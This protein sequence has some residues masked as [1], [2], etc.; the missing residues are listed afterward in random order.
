M[1][2][3]SPEQNQQLFS[4]AT[5]AKRVEVTRGSPLKDHSCPRCRVIRK[6]I[7]LRECDGCL[8]QWCYDCLYTWNGIRFRDIWSKRK[9]LCPECI[10]ECSCAKPRCRDV[11][12]PLQHQPDPIEFLF[13]DPNTESRN[14]GAISDPCERRAFYS[15]TWGPPNTKKSALGPTNSVVGSRA[16]TTNSVVG[17]RAG[18]TRAKGASR[19]RNPKR[20][21]NSAVAESLTM[22]LRRQSTKRARENRDRQPEH[23]AAKT[24]KRRKS[25]RRASTSISSVDND[26]TSALN[27]PLHGFTEAVRE[28]CRKQFS[29][30]PSGLIDMERKVREVFGSDVSQAFEQD[31]AMMIRNGAE[32]TGKLVDEGKSWF[33]VRRQ[34]RLNMESFC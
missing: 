6:G 22:P 11:N 28:F 8:K 29:E 7:C 5:A 26:N 25:D 4:T 19:R 17:S 18:T 21:S 20:A 3:S 15:P 13:T 30:G 10:G 31:V 27:P 14:W 32:C 16:G 24:T 23:L 1:H 34:V 12:L 2:H 9:F 33:E